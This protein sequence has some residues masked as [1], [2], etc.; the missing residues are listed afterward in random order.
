MGLFFIPS[1][2]LSYFQI[3]LIGF[4]FNIILK[5]LS[6]FFSKNLNIIY[7]L[8]LF[9]VFYYLLLYVLNTLGIDLFNNIIH[10][11]GNEVTLDVSVKGNEVSIKEVSLKTAGEIAGNIGGAGVFAAGLKAGT[12]LVKNS[13]LPIGLKIGLT[14]GTGLLSFLL[15]STGKATVK[16][17]DQN[18]MAN[19]NKEGHHVIVN[20]NADGN[21]T[22]EVTETGKSDKNFTWN[23]APNENESILDLDQVLDVLTGCVNINVCIVFILTVS[24]IFFVFKLLSQKQYNLD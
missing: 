24:I 17:F 11:E 4:Y 1:N 19:F 18:K 5:S 6:I 7:Y 14:G 20:K 16:L 8:L 23:K 13:S 10:L 12:T 21:F 2:V 9:T 15:Y 3:F 22:A